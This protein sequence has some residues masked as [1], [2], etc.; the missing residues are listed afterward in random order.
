MDLLQVGW[1]GCRLDGLVAGWIDW[2]S[3][4]WIG[5]RLDILVVD[6]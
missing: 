1:I 2:F 4:G 6:G 3:V 5:F